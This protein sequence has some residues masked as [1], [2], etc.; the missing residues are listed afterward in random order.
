MKTVEMEQ[1]YDAA[2]EMM[3]I[4]IAPEFDYSKTVVFDEGVFIDFDENDMPCAIELHHPSKKMRL[5]W[6]AYKG[7][8]MSATLTVT[9]EVLRFAF[10]TRVANEKIGCRVMEFEI[11][12]VDGITP[13]EFAFEI[14]EI[15][16][17]PTLDK[18]A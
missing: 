14:T 6:N 5:R 11:P 16:I 10:H 15:P 1:L 13:G 8:E 2:F 3:N 7:A 17:I 9:S 12:N 4:Q 18:F